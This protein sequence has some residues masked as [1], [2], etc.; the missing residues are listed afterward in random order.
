MNV[1]FGNLNLV[2]GQTV[3]IEDAQ[4][5]LFISWPG[6]PDFLYTLVVYDMSFPSVYDTSKSPFVHFFVTNIPG[7]RID[8]GSVVIDY[9]SP[10]PPVGSGDHLFVIDIY[11]QKSMI[12]FSPTNDRENID[13][14][15]LSAGLQFIGRLNFYVSPT[16]NISQI[17]ISK[18]KVAPMTIAK[19]ISPISSEFRQ[20]P[21][22]RPRGSGHVRTEEERE[23]YFK[24]D[25]TLADDKKKFCRTF[26]HVAAK[27]TENCNKEHAWYQVKD[28]KTCYNSF[29]IAAK[30]SG[31]SSRE[32]GKNFAFE[33][34]PDGELKAYAELNGIS[35][36]TPYD[37]NKILEN[38]RVWK[39]RN[40]P[41]K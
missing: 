19:P 31:T 18:V 37:R 21:V 28:G 29:S 14:K 12:N 39:E 3:N 20:S 5:D 26:L 32:C 13:V 25:S 11:L 6:N 9:L 27:Q 17:K 36:P 2:D 35:V 7:T 23:S 24:P 41:E 34:I 4:K 30:I 22:R 16:Q 40:Y 15:N 38:I 10:R 8:E 1:S 33:N